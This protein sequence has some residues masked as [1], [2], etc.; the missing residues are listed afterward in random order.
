MDSDQ[1]GYDEFGTDE[2]GRNVI[3][4]GRID[5]D[6]IYQLATTGTAGDGAIVIDGTRNG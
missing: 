3:W 6:A 1:A 4:A 5:R 2:D